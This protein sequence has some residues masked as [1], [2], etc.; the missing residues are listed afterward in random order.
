MAHFLYNLYN[1]IYGE[2]CGIDRQRT[3]LTGELNLALLTFRAMVFHLIQQNLPVSVWKIV[4]IIT[5]KH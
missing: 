2:I 1:F 3:V 5:T 4:P